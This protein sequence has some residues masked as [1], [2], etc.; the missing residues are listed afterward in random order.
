[1]N[2]RLEKAAALR[3]RMKALLAECDQA[4]FSM[5][6]IHLDWA[7]QLLPAPPLRSLS[8]GLPDQDPEP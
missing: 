6:A 4:G 5:T 7:I 1:M 8:T 2:P 3:K